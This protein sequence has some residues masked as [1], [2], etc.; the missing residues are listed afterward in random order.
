MSRIFILHNNTEHN[1]RKL[2]DNEN[3][4]ATNYSVTYS[5]FQKNSLIF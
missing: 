5:F 3:N 4:T 1:K 2:I